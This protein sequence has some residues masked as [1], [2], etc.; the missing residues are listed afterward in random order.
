MRKTKERPCA[1]SAP[2][3]ITK[4]D[5]T[6]LTVTSL[7]SQVQQARNESAELRRHIAKLVHQLDAYKLQE[8]HLRKQQEAD[9]QAKLT[10][11]ERD[12]A[13]QRHRNLAASFADRYNFDTKTSAIDPLT[14]AIVPLADAKE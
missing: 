3:H 11:Q 12:N 6:E 5:L 13:F 2:T 1:K 4:D 10:E 8:L 14:G 7:Q 9:A